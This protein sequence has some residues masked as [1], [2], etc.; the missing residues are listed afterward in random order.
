MIFMFFWSPQQAAQ[1]L[2]E[3]Y[4]AIAED[5]SETRQKNWKELEMLF[6]S[7]PEGANILDV[8]CGNGRLNILFEKKN[9]V[10]TGVD[11]SSK[12][13]DVAKKSFPETKFLQGSF[14]NLPCADESFDEVWTIASFHHLGSE[15]DR[16]KSLQEMQRVLKP[17]GQI[18]MTVWNLWD[19]E[20]YLP[21]KQRAFWRS[22]VFPKWKKRDFLIPWAAHKTPR[23]YH[24]FPYPE[25]EKLARLNGFSVV[26]CWGLKGDEKGEILGC[27]NICLRLQKET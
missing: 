22:L 17:G 9:C 21:H 1:K 12:L 8:G 16:M 27:K 24:S 5:F 13:L 14:T 23:Y 19:Q 7:T 10:V 20:K 25:L 2:S 26:E 4:D 18:V 6:E 15:E 11:I 3:V